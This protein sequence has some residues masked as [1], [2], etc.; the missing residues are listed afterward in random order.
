MNDSSVDSSAD[1]AQVVARVNAAAKRNRFIS[2]EDEAKFISDS[3]ERK[4]NALATSAI[5]L[6]RFDSFDFF[7]QFVPAGIVRLE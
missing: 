4:L 5:K 2:E 7:T 1:R 6:A 3:P